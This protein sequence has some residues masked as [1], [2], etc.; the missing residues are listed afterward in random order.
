MARAQQAYQSAAQNLQAIM[1]R[2][3]SQPG[4]AN[5]IPRYRAQLALAQQALE[6]LT[7]QPTTAVA[8]N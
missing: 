5:Q 3:Q 1:Q 6:A 2:A 4:L 7:G 8:R